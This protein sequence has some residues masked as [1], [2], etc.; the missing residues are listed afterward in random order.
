MLDFIKPYIRAVVAGL[1]LAAV[2]YI[3]YLNWRVAALKDEKA[4]LETQN[5]QLSADL[6]AQ[7]RQVAS[8]NAREVKSQR[9]GANY[10]KARNEAKSKDGGEVGPA[11]RYAIDTDLLRVAE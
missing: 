3:G 6:S 7:T 10:E 11:L 8:L 2:L 4:D 5:A 1:L 9:I